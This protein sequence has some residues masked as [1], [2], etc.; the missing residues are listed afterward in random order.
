MMMIIIIIIHG[1]TNLH[2]KQY[3][4]WLSR[5]NRL[6]S[7]PIN[8]ITMHVYLSISALTTRLRKPA[9]SCALLAITSWVS[10]QRLSSV[11]H[12]PQK[13]L[14]LGNRSALGNRGNSIVASRFADPGFSN[15]YILQQ[16]SAALSLRSSELRLIAAEV[17][18]PNW[19][20]SLQNPLLC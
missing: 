7:F 17:C 19:L 10:R 8:K 9:S 5:N 1:G 12:D 13:D 6:N 14:P 18:T 4:G 3:I 16:K 15:I 11:F 20:A 2:W